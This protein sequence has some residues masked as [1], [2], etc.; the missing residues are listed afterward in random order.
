MNES[1]SL[2]ASKINWAGLTAAG[3]GV[4]AALNVIPEDMQEKVTESALMVL[5]V[6]IPI[7]RTWF[8][9]KVIG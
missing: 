8:T 7:L 2:W 1:K 3:V 4:L 9:S 6:L 5:G